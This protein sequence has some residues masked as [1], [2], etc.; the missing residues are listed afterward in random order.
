MAIT[1]AAGAAALAGCFGGDDDSDGETVNP[2]Q[3]VPDHAD[4]YFRT[5]DGEHQITDFQYNPHI[6]GG[7]SHIQF[8][9]FDEWAQYLIDQDEY[10]PHFVEDWEFEDG[11]ARL[12]LRDDYTW[13]NGDDITAEDLVM[14]LHLGE[15]LDDDLFE[16]TDPD[17]IQAVDETTIEIEFDEGTNRDILRHIVLDRSLDHPPADWGDA[18]EELQ[19]EGEVNMFDVDIDEPTPSGPVELGDVG[20]QEAQFDIREDHP[21]SDNYNWNGYQIGYR[22]GNEAFHQSFASQ[23]LH[24]I[25]SLF[26]GPGAQGQFPNTLEQIQIPGG[27][28]M[29]IV[30]NHD[31]EHYGDREVRQAVAYAIDTE[32]SILTVG[33]D[34]K[35][36]FPVQ[37][38]L[39]VPAT[40]EWLDVDEYESYDQDLDMVEELLQEAGF[41][42]NGDDVWERDGSVLAAELQ[43][44]QGWGDWITPLS[45]I[46]DQLNQ[47]GFEAT[48]NS[49]DQGVW[50]ENLTNGDFNVAAYGHTEGGNAAMNYPFF[51]FSWKF[52][53]RDHTGDG[54]F[55]Y[56]E[57][58]EITVPDGDGGEISVNPREELNTIAN[59]NDESTIQE[60]VERL[61]RLFNEDLPMFLAQEKYEQ[62]FIDRDGWEFPREEDSQH[63]QA[64]WPLYWLP[65]QD[66]L[67]ATVAAE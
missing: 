11:L 3:E 34:T 29:G 60:S 41:E 38:G 37:S 44:P 45:T 24:G 32:E 12:H 22:S 64:F 7:F 20:E 66:E 35:L 43:G 5:A 27:F 57:D 10:Y 28:G 56:P 13:G 18:Y 16:F 2:D 14:Q 62:S 9:L 1:G 61:A 4:A 40:E 53:N 47:A 65:K 63:F 26:A 54:F 51:S 42:R 52:E 33:A 30:F 17:D 48:L 15:A 25:H 39:T 8:A 67:K 58:E 36:E 50:S 55:N 19:D 59:T 21:L 6:W 31:H 49:V 23:E 46:V